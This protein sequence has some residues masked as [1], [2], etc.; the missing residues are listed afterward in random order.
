MPSSI[1]TS[2]AAHKNAFSESFSVLV[3]K[4][5]KA[6]NTER[7]TKSAFQYAVG[8]MN[9]LKKKI[10]DVLNARVR[11]FTKNALT[12]VSMLECNDI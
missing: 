6:E 3:W 2:S 11:H 5:K 4:F 7:V 9:Y 12:M 1:I 10:I 8:W